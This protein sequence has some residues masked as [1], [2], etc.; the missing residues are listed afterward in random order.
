MEGINTSLLIASS[1]RPPDTQVFTMT[2]ING[3]D[4]LMVDFGDKDH[5]DEC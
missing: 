3:A 5:Y 1:S 4:G 2:V